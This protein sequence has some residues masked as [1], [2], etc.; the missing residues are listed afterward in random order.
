MREKVIKKLKDGH[1]QVTYYYHPRSFWDVLLGKGKIEDTMILDENGK[2]DGE[3]IFYR[4]D[5]SISGRAMHKKGLLVSHVIYDR[6]GRPQTKWKAGHG[7][8]T[9][10]YRPDGTKEKEITGYMTTSY[11]PTFE[12]RTR[13]DWIPDGHFVEYD[14]NEQV[15]DKG[16]RTEGKT[17]RD[18]KGLTEFLDSVNSKGN[19]KHTVRE[20]R[21]VFPKTEQENAERKAERMAR[22]KKIK[23]LKTQGK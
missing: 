3:S 4:R 6:E 9:Y 15:V 5:G 20:Y 13:A 17:I 23:E 21:E 1:I 14:Q 8:T 10:F 18:R 2:Q 22:Q 19:K 12:D 11:D 7:D 16:V